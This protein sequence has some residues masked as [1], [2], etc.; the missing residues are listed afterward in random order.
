MIGKV[1][2]LGHGA[3]LAVLHRMMGRKDLTVHGFRASFKTWS[4]EQT[5]YAHEI[6]EASL[7]HTIS[8]QLE[9]AYRRGDFLEKRA[10]LMAAWGDFCDGQAVPLGTAPVVALHA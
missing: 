2:L 7:T 6:V 10:R 3:L 1:V 8:G 9:R 5:N 4:S